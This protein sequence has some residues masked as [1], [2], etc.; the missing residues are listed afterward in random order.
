M[1][2]LISGSRVGG[3][4]RPKM[5]G[6]GGPRMDRRAWWAHNGQAGF[7]GLIIKTIVFFILTPP[8]SLKFMYQ[9]NYTFI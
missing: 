1:D 4:G 2:L 5:D 6:L 3:P 9:L 8:F 7:V